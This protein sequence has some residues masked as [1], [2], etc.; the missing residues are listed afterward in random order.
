[1][2]PALSNRNNDGGDNDA[3]AA[4]WFAEMDRW[5]LRDG[6]EIVCPQIFATCFQSDNA[7]KTWYLGMRSVIRTIMTTKPGC[8]NLFK[9]FLL[10]RFLI[11]DSPRLRRLAAEEVRELRPGVP[12]ATFAIC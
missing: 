1:V 4:V 12:C 10:M 8:W 7:L 2:L 11:G 5:V 3:C 6:E 9:K